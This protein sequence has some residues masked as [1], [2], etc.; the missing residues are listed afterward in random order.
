MFR[1]A[2]PTELGC[3]AR[4][5]GIVHLGVINRA[6]ESFAASQSPFSVKKNRRDPPDVIPDAKVLVNYL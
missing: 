2:D 3:A 4:S 6:A 5:N 1:T